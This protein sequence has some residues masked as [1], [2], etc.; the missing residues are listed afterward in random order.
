MISLIWLRDTLVD[1]FLIIVAIVLGLNFWY[2]IPIS[3]FI[4]G[5]RQH[6]LALL[7]H[8]ATHKL[9][10]RN[11]SVNYI[12]GNFLC[13][14]PIG[15]PWDGYREFHMS[16]HRWL[17]TTKDPELDRKIASKMVAKNATKKN[18]I[19]QFIKDLLGANITDIAK[20]NL[21]K[22]NRDKKVLIIVQLMICSLAIINPLIVFMWYIAMITSLLACSRL[23]IWHEHIGTDKTHLIKANWWQRLLF[24]PHAAEYHH[25]HHEKPSVPYNK[26]KDI[27]TGPRKKVSEIH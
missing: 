9:V 2:L 3:I 18:I 4:I 6:A 22:S 23:R 25:E 21:P 12:L 17:G 13:Y 15:L 5:N 14:A 1:W 10:S 26:L 20:F 19:I 24:L 8:D 11:T 16:H 7:G 27:A